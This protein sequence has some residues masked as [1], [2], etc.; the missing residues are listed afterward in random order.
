MLTKNFIFYV[1]CKYLQSITSALK[2][3]C[4]NT[5]VD[6]CFGNLRLH[7]NR[8]PPTKNDNKLLSKTSNNT[9]CKVPGQDTLVCTDSS[10]MRN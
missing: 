7:M 5:F 1:K 4:I 6:L 9:I 8:R 3:I 2:F 10:M